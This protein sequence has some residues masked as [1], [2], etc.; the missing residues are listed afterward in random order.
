MSICSNVT[1]RELNI[2]RELAEQQRNQ[3]ALKTKNRILKT[4]DIN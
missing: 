3:R 2:L 1:E 4:H